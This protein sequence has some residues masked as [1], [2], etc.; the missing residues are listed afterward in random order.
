MKEKSEYCNH[1][2][3]LY[4]FIICVCFVFI[5][6]SVYFYSLLFFSVF[7]SWEILFN[8]YGTNINVIPW[9]AG[10]QDKS[11]G[12]VEEIYFWYVVCFLILLKFNPSGLYKFFRWLFYNLLTT[13]Q[14]VFFFFKEV[15]APK[16]VSALLEG[17]ESFALSKHS[18][19]NV[20]YERKTPKCCNKVKLIWGFFINN[21]EL[22]LL[23]GFVESSWTL[24]VFFFFLILNKITIF[25]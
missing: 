18:K 8:Y 22:S 21:V 20:Y 9:S 7:D 17:T 6:V 5:L 14:V 11:D 13:W 10:T 15:A 24:N 12:L 23:K 3:L 1:V 2:S 4:N 16:G 25:I 19:W